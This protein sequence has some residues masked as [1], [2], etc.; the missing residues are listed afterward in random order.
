MT[1]NKDVIRVNEIPFDKGIPPK[2]LYKAAKKWARN[3][4]QGKTFVNKDTGRSIE[5]TGNGIDHT[6]ATSYNPDAVRL[7]AVLPDMI[8]RSQ[9]IHS[10]PPTPPEGREAPGTKSCSRRTIRDYRADTRNVVHCRV[11]R[12]SREQ[13]QSQNWQGR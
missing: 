7:L 12:Q 2:Q 8:E 4:F 11:D 10:E 3:Q 13:K 9:F 1:S 5:I 6:I